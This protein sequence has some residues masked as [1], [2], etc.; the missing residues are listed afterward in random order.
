MK[1]IISGRALNPCCRL[2]ESLTKAGLLKAE[3]T[4]EDWPD[5]MVLHV[6]ESAR[7]QFEVKGFACEACEE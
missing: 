4:W 2:I 5:K 6:P 7:H 3:I 1:V